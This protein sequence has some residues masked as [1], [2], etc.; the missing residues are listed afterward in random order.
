MSFSNQLGIIC[1]FQTQFY[2]MLLSVDSKDFASFY[3]SALNACHLQTKVEKNSDA[4][5]RSLMQF[6]MIA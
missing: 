6:H 4:K 2:F 3:H 5:R 1:F